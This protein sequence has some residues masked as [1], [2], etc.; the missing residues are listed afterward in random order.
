MRSYRSCIPMSFTPCSS[1][2]SCLSRS[3]CPFQVRQMRRL[4]VTDCSFR[5]YSSIRRLCFRAWIPW[6]PRTVLFPR[7]SDVVINMQLYGQNM[8]LVR[9]SLEFFIQRMSVFRWLSSADSL[10]VCDSQR[11]TVDDF[12]VYDVHDGS[13]QRIVWHIDLVWRAFWTQCIVCFQWF[14]HW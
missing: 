9:N 12:V 5:A 4:S 6:S 2:P 1:S 10:Q 13:C 3:C 8:E 11:G 14:L 7:R